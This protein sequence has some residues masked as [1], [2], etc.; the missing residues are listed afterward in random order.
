MS[1][2]VVA[3]V[4]EPFFTTKPT[5]RGTG[6]GLATVYGI[7]TQ[8]EGDVTI[9]SELGSGTIVRVDLPATTETMATRREARTDLRLSGNGETLL[10]VEDEQI[11]RDPAARLL[12]RH[13]Y[14]MLTAGNADDAITIVNDHQG[15]IALLLTDVVMPGRSGKE[16]SVAVTALRPAIKVLFMSGYSKNVI[17]SHGVLEQ[18]VNL[19]E[20]PFSAEE[21]LSKVRDVLD[22][23]S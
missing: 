7:V 10:L 14:S 22:D 17:G 19:I 1:P 20:K 23:D 5:G 11:V 21:L 18:G 4:F 15:T 9:D 3:R 6:L 13:G 16:L 8:A 12:T 2:D